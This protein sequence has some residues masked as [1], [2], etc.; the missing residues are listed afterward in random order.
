MTRLGAWKKSS[1][2][3]LLC[4][5]TAIAAPVQ[6]FT[7]LAT[8]HYTQGDQPL[9]PLIQG[10]D[11]NLYGTTYQGGDGGCEIRDGCGTLFRI[12][13]PG[14]LK[15]SP[16]LSAANPTTG[17][18]LATDGNFYGTTSD[19][20]ENFG[21]SVLKVTPGGGLTTLYTFCGQLPCAD[22]EFP[23]ALIQAVDG[24]FYGTT[25][26]GGAG[27]AGTVFKLTPEGVLTT[28]YSF[29]AQPNCIDGVGPA[30]AL[31]QA[32]DGDFYGTTEYGGRGTGGRNP[33]Y[34]TVFRITPAGTL[35]TLV[36]FDGMNGAQPTGSLI[37][38][39]DGSLYG[40]THIGGNTCDPYISG[41]GT[42]FKLS[43]DAKL[44]TLHS[45]DCSDGAGP[46]AGLIQATDG[47]FYGTTEA[48][49]QS[50]NAPFGGGTVFKITADGVLTVLHTFCTE[51]NCT[52][53]VDPV[54][55]LVQGTD[56]IFY[57]SSQGGDITCDPY[58][59]AGWCGTIFS[60]DVGLGPFVTYVHAAGEVGQTGGILGQ[61]FTGTTSVL[62]NGIPASFTV[63]SDTFIRATVPAGATTGFVTVVTPS[64]TLTSNV[65]FHVIP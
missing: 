56:G 8:F 1:A 12:T 38:G 28:L 57:G 62:L 44:K 58:R 51:P 47:N 53:G 43:S 42:V 55:G 15:A 35:T 61:G 54:A 5:A 59:L 45:F 14:V 36:A 29:C 64:G 65:P 13:P 3:F 27:Q 37:Q 49:G 41:A 50:K 22:G 21:G 60:L 48:G 39:S 16:F 30:A 34:G 7:N 4:A 20:G 6:V 11:G 32:A 10:A 25:G 40:T 24:N 18:V 31:L 9:A 2:V 63:V 46:A 33:G 23:S 17:L 19:A 26:G 52:D